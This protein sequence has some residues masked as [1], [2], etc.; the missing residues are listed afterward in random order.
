MLKWREQSLKGQSV[1][2][3]QVQQIVEYRNDVIAATW[4]HSVKQ[5]NT[6]EN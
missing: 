2:H 6:G 3:Y 4:S 5:V 1:A